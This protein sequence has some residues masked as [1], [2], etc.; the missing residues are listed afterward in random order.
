MLELRVFVEEV[1]ETE[2]HRS[3]VERG[4][5]R[6]EGRGGQN[7]LLD[8]HIGAAA[9]GDVDHRVGALLDPRQKAGERLRRLVR[10]A[11]GRVARVQ[12]EDRRSR[13]GRTNRV[14]DDFVRSHRQVR[15]H[16]RRVDGAGHRAGDDHLAR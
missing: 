10:L 12:M 14:V 2:I 3:H 6:F 8:P 4:D 1:V 7:P 5:L 16:R 15:R 13:L 9:G 11:V